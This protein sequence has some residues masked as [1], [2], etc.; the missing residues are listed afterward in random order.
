MIDSRSITGPPSTSAGTNYSSQPSNRDDVRLPVRREGT[1][2]VDE[3]MVDVDEVLEVNASG[4]LVT[5]LRSTWMQVEGSM[6][7]AKF[8]TAS[9]GSHLPACGGGGGGDG[10]GAGAGGEG[11]GDSGDG[12]TRGAAMATMPTMTMMGGDIRDANG[13]IYLNHPSHLVKQMIEC[14]QATSLEEPVVPHE[15][16]RGERHGLLMDT[17]DMAGMAT[18]FTIRRDESSQLDVFAPP[19]L[20]NLPTT[21]TRSDLVHFRL[22]LRHYLMTIAVYRIGVF[23]LNLKATGPPQVDRL[24][25]GWCADSVNTVTVKGNSYHC[26]NKT[27]GDLSPKKYVQLLPLTDG[28]KMYP[29]ADGSGKVWFVKSFE[30]DISMAGTNM[31]IFLEWRTVQNRSL[32]CKISGKATFLSV[33]NY[34]ETVITDGELAYDGTMDTERKRKAYLDCIRSGQ[35]AKPIPHLVFCQE[36]EFKIRVIEVDF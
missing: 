3:G 12:R 24:L 10:A 33:Q 8:H 32:H 31:C 1:D 34:G 22:M 13:R 27:R 6:L 9:A 28:R 35:A 23:Q 7:R 21:W 18:D 4:T 14:L 36:G 5:A 30:V 29:I 26:R 11:D 15:D 2:L 19:T 25:L 17:F 20:D 16:G